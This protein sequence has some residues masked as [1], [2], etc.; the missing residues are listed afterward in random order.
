MM[1]AH[2]NE[3]TSEPASAQSAEG[4]AISTAKRKTA[5]VPRPKRRPAGSED[6]CAA[7]A[8]VTGQMV[9]TSLPD[10][11]VVDALCLCAF[12][13]LAVK[14]VKGWAWLDAVHPD[15]RVRTE[16]LWKQATTGDIPFEMECRVRRY[17]GTYCW[18]AVRTAPVRRAN[19]DVGEWVSAASVDRDETGQRWLE[20]QMV[21]QAS[22]FEAIFDAMPDPVVVFDEAGIIRQ[23]NI[24]DRKMFGFDTSAT[25]HPRS[26]RERGQWL[27]LRD[28]RGSL[29]EQQ[30]PAFRVLRGEL[31]D[32][33]EAV[34][35]KARTLDGR[36]LEVSEHGAPIY[37][38]SGCIIGGVLV[39]RDVTERRKLERRTWETLQALLGIV[40]VIVGQAVPVDQSSTPDTSP[41]IWYLGQLARSVLGCTR[42]SIKVLE[43]ETERMQP[44]L[45]VG[46]P[47]EIEQQWS[48]QG[49]RFRLEDFVPDTLLE[50]LRAGEAVVNDTTAKSP[51]GWPVR[52]Q[53]LLA[54]LHIESQLIGVLVVDYGEQS[55]QYSADERLLAGA[56]AQLAAVVVERERMLHER[57]GAH[58][59]ELASRETTRRMELFMAMAGHE[60]RAPLTVIKRYLQL[61]EQQLDAALP[62][63]E[64]AAPLARALQSA[65]ESL[66]QTS[67]AAIR[68]TSLLDDLLQVSRAQAGQLHMR[69]QLCDLNSI[70]RASVE[71]QQR[72]NPTRQVHLRLPESQRVSV[73]AD[74]ERIGQVVTNYL[75]NAFRFSPKNRP[76]DVRVQLQ[77][78]VAH[79]SVRDGGPG[80]SPADQEHVWDRF[81]QSTSIERTPGSD[82]G[83]GLGLYICRMIVEQHQGKVGVE[84]SVGSSST[85]W[86]ALPLYDDGK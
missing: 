85:F 53:A 46:W 8:Q 38:T 40:R 58:A 50:R 86:F 73:M 33:S 56:V 17:D 76:V 27:M 39:V 10:G 36:E 71:E 9:W 77:G 62:Y 43:P 13:G 7:L 2:E 20:Q 52:G 44:L 68:M 22:Q 15:D 28:E 24:A 34:E 75:T 79:V 35:L 67:H 82:A 83:L 5:R 29:S 80:L 61:T 69:P 21:E 45:R 64:S 47:A 41:V 59:S 42:L 63:T 32:G 55:H 60:F 48:A 78:R 12:T 31:L 37:D 84:S 49:G 6:R 66:D 16:R 23:D 70:V 65:H 81:Y 57:E 51:P 3:L 30:W 14:Q 25:G 26:L 19:G 18:F 54:P 74:P 4:N 11:S 72:M 1:H